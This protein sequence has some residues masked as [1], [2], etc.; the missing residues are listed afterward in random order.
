MCVHV[1]L[2]LATARSALCLAS[3]NCKC[4]GFVNCVSLS[5]I[6]IIG[7]PTTRNAALATA[8][9]HMC[10]ASANC[11]CPVS[12]KCVCVI[13][14]CGCILWLWLQGGEVS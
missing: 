10:L 14:V 4:F 1:S 7:I 2:A 8:G 11:M 12:E 3:A 6:S 5:S 9:S 13:N